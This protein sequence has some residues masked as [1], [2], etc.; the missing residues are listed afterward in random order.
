MSAGRNVGVI[1]YSAVKTKVRMT[2]L[3]GCV[4][5]SQ[6]AHETTCLRGNDLAL[7]QVE[8][9]RGDGPGVRG[10]GHDLVRRNRDLG[11]AHA[12]TVVVGGSDVGNDSGRRKL[13]SHKL[14]LDLTR[15]IHSRQT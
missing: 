14:K 15:V 2:L 9:D 1:R 3:N 12:P 13:E 8:A 7:L 5:Q 6:N 4:A 10:D 11:V